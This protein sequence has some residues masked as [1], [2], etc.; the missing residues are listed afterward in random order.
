MATCLR[1]AWFKSFVLPL[2]CSHYNW[3]DPFCNVSHVCA[4]EFTNF[5]PCSQNLSSQ[6]AQKALSSVS[7]LQTEVNTFKACIHPEQW[8]GSWLHFRRAQWIVAFLRG[9]T[10]TNYQTLFHLRLSTCGHFVG[11]R[12]VGF[13]RRGQKSLK[14][15]LPW[16]DL[17]YL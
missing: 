3:I 10:R 17:Y 12:F 15:F 6:T 5:H 14:W 4:K 7:Y 16:K 9:K 8:H 13:I 2:A 11:L 1:L